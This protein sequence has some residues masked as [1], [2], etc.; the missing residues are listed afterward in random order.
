MLVVTIYSWLNFGGPASPGRG[1]AAGRKFL[2]RCSVCVSLSAFFIDC[3]MSI[4]VQSNEY[5]ELCKYCNLSAQQSI[6]S[7]NI[8]CIDN[9]VTRG[10]A[11]TCSS[12]ICV[13]SFVWVLDYFH[14]CGLYFVFL[15]FFLVFVFCLLYCELNSNSHMPPPYES[16]YNKFRITGCAR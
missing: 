11:V 5:S 15:S 8:V 2:V 16:G 1:S 6:A 14:H 3:V 10:L 7:I 12:F 13:F 9:F 4:Y